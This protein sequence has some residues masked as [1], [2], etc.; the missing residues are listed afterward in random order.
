VKSLLALL[1]LGALLSGCVHSVKGNLMTIKIERKP[2]CKV[3][4]DMD[5]AL[6]FEGI[7]TKPCPKE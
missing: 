4:V 7:G 5:G 3:T 2:T 1:T 6:V